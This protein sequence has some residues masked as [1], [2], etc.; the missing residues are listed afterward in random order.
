MEKFD[1]IRA[2]LMSRRDE[3]R[4]RLEQITHD[5]R[6]TGK[7]LDQDFAEQAVERENDEVLDA[8]GEAGRAELARINRALQR[9]EHGEY[10]NCVI[11]GNPIPVERLKVL[12]FSEHCV[13]CAEEA[14]R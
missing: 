10:G 7:P 5:V 1:E 11:C 6:R 12:P 8:L 14:E 9:I 3:L 4:Q 13:E 2:I